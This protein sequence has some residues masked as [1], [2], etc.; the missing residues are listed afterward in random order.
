MSVSI[1]LVQ[2]KMGE[3]PEE[4]LRK[5]VGCI[6]EAAKKGAQV[7]CLPELFTTRYFPQSAK[8]VKNLPNTFFEKIPGFATN[9]LSKAAREHKVILIGGS[10][11]EKTGKKLFNT[12]VVFD[13]NG[14]II[15]TYRKMHIPK[16]D[17]FFEQDYFAPGDEG[18][19][20]FKTSLAK[21]G[22]L[23]CYDQWFP[24]A[25]RINALLGA[26]II[27]YPTAIGTVEGI[28]Q[29]EGNWKE[30]WENVM[31]GH[32]IANG[33]IV[34]AVNRVGIEGKMRFWGGSF[35]CDAFGKTIA[36]AGNGEQVLVCD[37]DLEHGKNV[38]EGWRFFY[39]R[40][41]GEYA[42]LTKK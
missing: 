33:M 23:I 31:R 2:M 24:E 10:I 14:E 6:E 26:D 21:I 12:S 19:Q 40:R 28:E 1:G 16:D 3:K 18:F 32:A 42:R 8:D 20:A 27:F 25:A 39:N 11:Y 37:V 9:A 13:T 30:A 34:A 35:V 7:I 36:R 17:C 29:T 38:R 22:V 15:G 5:A 4:N 41:P